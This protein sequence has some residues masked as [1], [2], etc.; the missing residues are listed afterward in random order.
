MQCTAAADVTIVSAAGNGGSCPLAW[1][2]LQQTLLWKSYSLIIWF[3]LQ[4]RFIIGINNFNPFL[5]PW[6]WQ[7]HTITTCSLCS[8]TLDVF[9]LVCQL[10]GVDAVPECPGDQTRHRG[11]PQLREV[12]PGAPLPHRQLHAGGEPR[13]RPLQEGGGGG[14]PELPPAH[15][16]RGRASWTSG[17]VWRQRKYRILLFYSFSSQPGWM[18]SSSFS[19]SR[20]RPPSTPSTTT[21]PKWPSTGTSRRSPS[22]LSA[23]KVRPHACLSNTCLLLWIFD[24]YESKMI[25]F[26]R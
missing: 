25:N 17:E 10:P 18:L 21:T 1:S 5:S 7:H 23:P 16:G 26:L 22:S 3:L 8:L 9:R 14:R 20:T 11:Q 4:A 24:F 2:C 6:V 13:G 15:Q 12:R 19:V